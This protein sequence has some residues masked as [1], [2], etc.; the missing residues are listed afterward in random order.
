M[1]WPMVHFGIA[2]QLYNGQ[3]SPSFLL[4]SIAPDAIHTR[5]HVTR[6]EKGATHFVTGGRFPTIAELEQACVNELG[7]RG[8]MDR[9]DFV[10]GYIAHVY[11]DIRW[12]DTIYA[13]FERAYEDGKQGRII[14]NVYNE[15]MAQTE[16]NLLRTKAWSDEILDALRRAEIDGLEPLVSEH[17]VSLY[18]EMKLDYLSEPSH[19]PKIE[20]VYFTDE[21]VLAF[22]ARTAEELKLL[23]VEWEVADIS[24]PGA[25]SI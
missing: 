21:A 20:S 19:E 23:F 15:E 5:G 11:A 13:S 6:E 14:R 4:G 3:P 16:F 25:A 2:V 12:T 24:V 9:A 8:E 22:I 17:E 7:K 10:L 1:P 18:R